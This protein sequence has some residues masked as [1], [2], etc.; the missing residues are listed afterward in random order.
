LI[1]LQSGSGHDEGYGAS[2]DGENERNTTGTERTKS[3]AAED[4][5]I[6]LARLLIGSG[7]KRS[8]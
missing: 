7:P 8:S 2:V 3:E 4:G 1:L 5:Q 6:F